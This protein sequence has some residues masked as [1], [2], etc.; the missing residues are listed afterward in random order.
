M[1]MFEGQESGFYVD[2]GAHHPQRFSNTYLFYLKG[3]KGINIDA[4]PG[5]MDSFKKIRP[6]DINLEITVSDK[7]E[8][9]TYYE[10]DEPALN[11][12]SVEL[13][14]EYENLSSHRIIN[15]IKVKAKPL[16]D[17]LDSYLETGQ[18]IDFISIDVEGLDYQVL[19]SNDWK[20][21]RPKVLVIEDLE[22]RINSQKTQIQA[23]L[24]D[25]G[26]CLYSRLVNS[27]I[28]RNIEKN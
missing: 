1:R 2:I 16:S 18:S 28:F 6:R 4:M 23:F 26:Y 8:I 10:F 7:E 15:E 11:G 17:V 25:Q 9:L 14:K 12:C 13:S 22:N 3:W 21:W 27:A 24:E 20:K 5:S 19:T